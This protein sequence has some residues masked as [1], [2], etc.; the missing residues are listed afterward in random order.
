MAYCILDFCLLH[1][2]PG[3]Q[4]VGAAPK[5][6]RERENKKRGIWTIGGGGVFRTCFL[7]SRFPQYLGA[8]NR[9]A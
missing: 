8:S 6:E 5:L 3:S 4:I 9:L 2:V 1:P 7:K